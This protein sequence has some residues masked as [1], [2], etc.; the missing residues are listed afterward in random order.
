MIDKNDGF[1]I[2][3]IAPQELMNVV[4][5]LSPKAHR[6]FCERRQATPGHLNG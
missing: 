2:N 6:A 3:T 1:Y 4:F 5:T